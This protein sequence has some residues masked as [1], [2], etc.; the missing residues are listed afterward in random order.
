MEKDNLEKTVVLKGKVLD[1][2]HEGVYTLSL[3]FIDNEEVFHEIKILKEKPFFGSVEL[4][5]DCKIRA[6]LTG[7]LVKRADGIQCYNNLFVDSYEKA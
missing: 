3:L 4:N 6:T 1:V 2:M 5:K 7:K